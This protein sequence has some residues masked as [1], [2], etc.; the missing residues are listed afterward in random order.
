MGT[1]FKS[2]YCYKH[3]KL[4][5]LRGQTCL[6]KVNGLRR[7]LDA[8][9]QNFHRRFSDGHSIIQANFEVSELTVK[10]L[11][12][13]PEG[14]FV[15]ECLVA[16]EELLAPDKVRLFQSFCSVIASVCVI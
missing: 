16:A 4:E 2:L 7:R 15:S 12:P 13:L 14:E 3:A 8:Q 6:G 5:E 11:R 10:K 9:Q 1:K